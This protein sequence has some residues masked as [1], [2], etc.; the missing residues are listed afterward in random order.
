MSKIK[1]ICV[2]CGSGPGSDPRFIEAAIALGKILAENRI[3]LV[4]G[5]GSIGLMGAL[6]TSV[7]DHGGTVTGIIPD[8]LTSRENALTRVQE[9]VVTPDMHERKRLMFE[10]SDAFVALPGGVGTL[11]EL[12]E[13]LTWKQLGRHTKPVL[14][15]NID[16]FWEPLL[17]LLAHMRSTQFIRPTLDVD[18]LKAERVDDIL[19]RLRAAAARAPVGTEELTPELARRL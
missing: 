15:A 6:A 9:L 19:P 12:V 10:R 18:V 11:E 8:F 14:L 1:T 2:Y 7:L 3:R 16:G 5:G 17:A 13:Q 4:Y